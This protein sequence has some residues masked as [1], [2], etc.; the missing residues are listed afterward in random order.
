QE[1]VKIIPLDRLLIETDAPFLAPVPMRGKPNEPSYVKHT[2][3]FL[4]NHLG[5]SFQELSSVTTKN[6]F[7]LFSKTER[8][9]LA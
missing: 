8:P 6:F 9:D 4:S 2:A 5:V 7:D 1:A 3:E